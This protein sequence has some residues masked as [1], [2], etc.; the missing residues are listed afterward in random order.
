MFSKKTK[1]IKKLIFFCFFLNFTFSNHV[2]ASESKLN[3][4]ILEHLN[5]YNEFSS[6]FIQIDGKN[7]QEGSLFIKNNR[8]RIDYPKPT[9]ILIIIKE[10]KAMYYNRG[11]EEVEYFNPKKSISSIFFNLFNDPDFLKESEIISEESLVYFKKNISIMDEVYVVNIFFEKKPILLKK[12]EV[13]E[14]GGKLKF[15][16]INPNFNPDLDDK[17]FSL[18]HPLLN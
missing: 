10:N 6:E 2:N 14:D 11:L 1:I 17:I 15:F 3:E 16:F 5:N 13:E 12:V 4:K 8:L 7:V 9:D 18:A